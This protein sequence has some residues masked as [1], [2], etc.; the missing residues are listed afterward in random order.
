[1]S[2]KV[3]PSTCCKVAKSAK[4][5]PFVSSPIKGAYIS[6]PR[7]VKASHTQKQQWN[8]ILG[9]LCAEYWQGPIASSKLVLLGLCVVTDGRKCGKLLGSLW[10][11]R[12]WA[13]VYNLDI[14]YA[15]APLGY[16]IYSQHFEC[17]WSPERV[18]QLG[19]YRTLDNQQFRFNLT[20]LWLHFPFFAL[21][22]HTCMLL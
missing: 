1:M 9:H 8:T 12:G 21:F 5:T 22:Q 10:L 7:F 11:G 6:Q 4:M 14:C 2:L 16:H 18:E 17:I 3:T 13:R 19:W 15:T 20:K